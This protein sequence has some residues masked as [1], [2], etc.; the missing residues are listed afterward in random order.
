MLSQL[1]FTDSQNT[2]GTPNN[3]ASK[4]YISDFIPK[5]C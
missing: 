3:V 2:L 4:W 5:N 1:K